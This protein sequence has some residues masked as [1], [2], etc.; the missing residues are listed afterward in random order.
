MDIHAIA[1]RLE[2]TQVEAMQAFPRIAI[3]WTEL[4]YPGQNDNTT[5]VEQ[6][7]S[8][9]AHQR[10][11]DAVWE[12]KGRGVRRPFPDCLSAQCLMP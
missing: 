4:Q 2:A 7:A 11:I 1:I 5:A 3:I 6:N 9:P 10:R 12:A 8:N